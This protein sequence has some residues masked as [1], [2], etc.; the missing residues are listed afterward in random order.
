MLLLVISHLQSNLW[1]TVLSNQALVNEINYLKSNSEQYNAVH[2][3]GHSIVLAG[4]GSGKTKTLTVAMARALMEDVFEPR[5]VAC[6]TYNNECSIELE[7]R[8]AKLGIQSSDRAFIGT[9]HSF[10][11]TQIIMPYSRCIAGMLPLNYRVATAKECHEAAESAFSLVFNSTG[12]L[13]QLWRLADQKRRRDVDR[14]LPSWQQQDSELVRFIEAYEACLRLKGLIDF[15]DMPLIAFRIVKDNLWVRSALLA[16]FPVLFVDEYQDLGQALHE[17]VL[18]LCFE[19]G[20]R[21][22]AVGDIDQSIYGFTGA[23]PNLLQSLTQRHDITSYRLRFNYRSGPKIISASLGA[24][25]EER[26]YLSADISNEG[27]INFYPVIGNHEVQA[28]FIATNVLPLLINK[29]FQ[30]DQIAILYRTARFGDHV[31]KA[32]EKNGAIYIRTD[33]SALIKRSSKLARFI[34]ACASWVTG[35]WRDANPPYDK[36][37]NQAVTIVYGSFASETEKQ[38]LSLQLMDFLHSGIGMGELANQWLRRFNIEIIDNWKKISRNNNPEWDVFQDM[39]KKTEPNEKLEIDLKLFAGRV[40]GSRRFTLSTLHSVKGREFDVVVLFGINNGDI[41][42]WHDNKN[43]QALGEARRLFYVGVTRPR[44]ELCLVY[45]K[46][47]HSPW[48]HDLY[49]RSQKF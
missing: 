33:S 49:S 43:P 16:R 1:W 47:N 13:N 36:L 14:R 42:N 18:L 45:Q 22:F 23:N 12:D 3:R 19:S 38:I 24:L 40:E 31:A 8:L 10:A 44:K 30:P 35:G 48:V 27:Q 46:H 29:G 21:L 41:P 20:I 15:D 25:G 4:P 6:I 37:I 17:L 7:S 26:N 2:E 11:L 5:G 39:I 9:V 28:N 32:L 34:E